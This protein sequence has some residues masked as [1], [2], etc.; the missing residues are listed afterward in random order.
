MLWPFYEPT[1]CIPLFSTQI[2]WYLAPWW[3][4]ESNQVSWRW[5]SQGTHPPPLGKVTSWSSL[6]KLPLS[7]SLPQGVGWGLLGGC[8]QLMK[9]NLLLEI[10]MSCCSSQS[11]RSPSSAWR[12]HRV[13]PP[14][15]GL[16]VGEL[17]SSSSSEGGDCSL[18]GNLP[19]S[20][21]HPYVRLCRSYY[22]NGNWFV[23]EFHCFHGT[24]WCLLYFL[25]S[26]E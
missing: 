18:G 21:V 25:C 12:H 15:W 5:W 14:W 8:M 26:A 9:C 1:G 10:F 19:Y 4:M 16:P 20:D 3:F 2:W 7:E 13:P 23:T 17:V 6:L 11:V 22:L 24:M